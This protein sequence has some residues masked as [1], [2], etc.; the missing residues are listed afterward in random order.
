MKDRTAVKKTTRLTGG[1][2][3]VSL[4]NYG[5]HLEYPNPIMIMLTTSRALPRVMK[6]SVV[7]RQGI[8]EPIPIM[9]VPSIADSL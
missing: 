6:L 8:K 1:F 3:F 2:D 7:A 9:I 5:C 4:V